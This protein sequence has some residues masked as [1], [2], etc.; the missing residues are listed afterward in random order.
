VHAKHP[1]AKIQETV[2]IIT[3]QL[4]SHDNLAQSYLL[5]VQFGNSHSLFYL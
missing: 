2:V 5:Q 1:T 4:Y 3:L